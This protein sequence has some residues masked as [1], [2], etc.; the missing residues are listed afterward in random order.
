MPTTSSGRGF[1]VPIPGGDVGVWGP[2]I[3]N[4]FGFLDAILA[5]TATFPSTTYGNSATPTSSQAQTARLVVNNTSSQAFT[6]NLPAS[7]FSA[8]PY[9]VVNNSSQGQTLTITAG[10]SGTG[11]TSVTLP[12]GMT[13]DIFNDGINITLRDSNLPTSSFAVATSS[14][15]IAGLQLGAPITLGNGLGT[16][17]NQ[18]IVS[19]T[20]PTVQNFTTAGSTTYFPTSTSVQRAKVRMCGGGGGGGASFSG[21]GSSG[22]TT[23]FG[24]W[25]AIGGAGGVTNAA[26]IAA[27]GSGGANGTGVLDL[28]ING[29][30]GGPSL[31]AN[32]GGAGAMSPFFSG[33][34]PN[35]NVSTGS[36]AVANT[37]A[38]GGAGS[39]GSH[40]GSGGASGEYVEFWVTAPS[41]GGT[42]LTVGAGGVGGSSGFAGAAGGAGAAGVINVKEYY[43]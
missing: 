17:S 25:T 2:P 11:G 4:T 15:P 32:V 27:G 28:R 24:G 19:Q 43:I 38:G 40:A 9:T 20:A 16:S 26:G 18:I 10:S 35:S 37:G 31:S 33:G 23:S 30:N 8:A 14:F 34:A 29:T 36:A 5:F 6:L 12:S 22:A 21:N 41:T 13:R 7:N 3:S 39:D 42:A 1:S